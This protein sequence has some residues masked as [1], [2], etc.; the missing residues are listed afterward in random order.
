VLAEVNMV[1]RNVLSEKTHTIKWTLLV[2]AFA[3]TLGMY[4]QRAIA[5]EADAAA[6]AAVGQ[7]ATPPTAEKS[8]S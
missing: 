3:L 2:A 7:T 1:R 5:T 6:T 4:A 8:A